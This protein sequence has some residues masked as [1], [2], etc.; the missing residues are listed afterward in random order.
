MD[1]KI[2]GETKEQ[3]EAKE[4]VP[5]MSVSPAGWNVTNPHSG[6]PINWGREETRSWER[7][8]AHQR[9]LTGWRLKKGVTGCSADWC[10]LVR[11]TPNGQYR[12]LPFVI[13]KT[14]VGRIERQSP[15]LLSFNISRRRVN[16][17]TL[18]DVLEKHQTIFG[19]KQSKESETLRFFDTSLPS[20]Q[21]RRRTV[22]QSTNHQLR[23]ENL[24][25][26]S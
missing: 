10:R 24:H 22:P 16:Q 6:L 23:C 1:R 7:S 3:K 15:S 18:S 26:P 5:M 11:G 8:G 19:V 20:Y 13:Y 17:W 14:D 21:S 25:E 4:K 12:R 2:L 9:V